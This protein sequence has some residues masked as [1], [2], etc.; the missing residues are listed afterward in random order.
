MADQPPDLQPV[1]GPRDDADDAG[2][3]PPP[4]L[5]A[6]RTGG[7]G[8]LTFVIA[9]VVAVVLIV[10]SVGTSL[11]RFGPPSPA[12]PSAPPV[13]GTLAVIDDVGTLSSLDDPAGSPVTYP[14]AG[15]R[16]QFPTW[17]PDG[18]HLAVVG[19]SLD[20]NGQTGVYVF[21]TPARGVSASA[22]AL[23]YR[24]EVNPPFYLYW[25]PDGRQVTFL[26]SESD[27]L[28]LR[29][30]PADATAPGATI[31]RGSPLYWTFVD[32]SRMLIHSGGDASGAFVG[33]VG[34]DGSVI[35]PAVGAPGLFRPPAVS[36]DGRYRAYAAPG[37]RAG[38]IGRGRGDRRLSS[39]RGPDRRAR[40][41]RVRAGRRF[42]R[43]HRRGTARRRGID[44]DRS[45]PHRRPRLRGDPDPAERFRRRVLLVAGREDHRGP[46][47]RRDRRRWHRERRGHRVGGRADRGPRHRRRTRLRRSCGRR[48]QSKRTVSLGETF[49][50]QI[51][52]YFD[53]YALSHRLWSPDSRSIALPTV[54]EAGVNQVLV[55]S[56]DGAD[57][58]RVAGGVLAFWSPRGGRPAD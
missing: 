6:V 43:L 29:V 47:D 39:P 3:D 18:S 49:V 57:A 13:T 7:P 8:L 54:D 2:A 28:A 41:R 36:T 30:A 12:I 15:L 26:T 50:D 24:S 34:L 19:T 35:D 10:G 44:P 38:R 25:T 1:H 55:L 20:G 42:V 51:L 58:H 5:E 14:G 33:V 4:T 22:A 45:A 40:R 48:I 56:A 17:S 11:V 53:Q 21:D 52:P 16:F 27:G 37:D 23:I 46:A 32:G 9:V 31:R